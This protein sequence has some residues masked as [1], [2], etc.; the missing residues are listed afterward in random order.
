MRVVL[1]ERDADVRGALRL[2]L[3]HELGMDVV[4]EAVDADD[5]W[6]AVQD[7]ETDLLLVEWELLGAEPD[8]AMAHLHA[9]SPHPRVIAV[10]GH[11]E[12]CRHAITVGA[13]AFVCKADPPEQVVQ[14]LRAIQAGGGTAPCDG[15]AS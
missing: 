5:L 4:A 6:L 15:A 11:P 1:A 12:V 14:T 8:R 3:I 2:L 13:D 7:T 10:S 9:L